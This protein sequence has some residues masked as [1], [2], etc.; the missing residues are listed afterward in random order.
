M[1]ERFQVF[2][3]GEISKELSVTIEGGPGIRGVVDAPNTYF[4][5]RPPLTE[6]EQ[7]SL[8]DSLGLESPLGQL[9]TTGLDNGTWLR[10]EAEGAPNEKHLI[11]GVVLAEEIIALK[12][13]SGGK[14]TSVIDEEV[15]SRL[16]I[17]Q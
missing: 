15:T 12:G 14:V 9:L 5:V 3:I 17:P 8:I 13:L 1:P 4:E 11:L 16:V 7:S 10:L 6:D 2:N